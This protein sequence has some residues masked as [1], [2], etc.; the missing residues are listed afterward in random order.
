MRTLS[1]L[2]L[3]VLVA[4]GCSGNSGG[5][6]LVSAA[7]K[8]A[9][10]RASSDP[11]QHVVIVMQENRSFDNFFYQYP[12]ANYATQGNGH[13]GK[14]Y[15]LEEL[16]LKW[17][18]DQNHYHWQ[19]L[20]DYDNGAG[21][22]FDYQII[23]PY[24][25]GPGC[26]KGNWF[27]EP[28]C[29]NFANDPH[30]QKIMAQPYSYVTRAQIQPYWD[31]ANQYVLGDDTFASNNGPTFVSHQYMIA[32]QAGHASEVPS[33]TPWGCNKPRE[34]ENYLLYG[35]ADPPAFDPQVGHEI[36]GPDPC[37]PNT[38]AT[39]WNQWH[40]PTIATELDNQGIS[41]RYYVQPP[42]RDSYWLN[43]F[44]A[45]KAVFNGPDWKSDISSPDTNVLTDITSGNLAQVSWVM[46]HG[47]ASDHPGGG[48][49]NCGPDWV[50]SIVNAVGKS[51]YWNNTAIIIMWDE[52]GGWYDHVIPPQ[53]ADP[54]TGAQEGLGFRV[55][56][57]IVSPYAKA[58]YISH[59]QHEIASTLHFIE[60]T[61]DLPALGSNFNPPVQLADQRA[62]AFD[63]AFDFTQS[64]ITFKPIT[65]VNEPGGLC[66]L[67]T[68]GL[69]SRKWAPEIDY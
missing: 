20:E 14:V 38:N 34:S 21:D 41:W 60:Q 39:P 35:V 28:Q 56:L 46:P 45:V 26:T 64:P 50:A 53:Y 29:W 61:F 51:Q 40:Y 15:Q 19:F 18:R 63:D 57:L 22:G 43:A 24:K 33:T 49:G 8:N 37:F 25:S 69:T 2:L 12:G 3:F 55:P 66:P 13:N 7:S 1:L 6:S 36:N 52:W 48:S 65:L 5:T 30:D 16:P 42:T 32:A 10:R 17:A 67:T 27:N 59:Q 68:T 4:S 44:A 62:D 9:H 47:G 58:G 23:Q 11:I 31:M 54:F